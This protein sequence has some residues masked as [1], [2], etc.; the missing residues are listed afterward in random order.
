MLAWQLQIALLHRCRTLVITR[1]N[2]CT[3]REARTL[4]SEG[5]RLQGAILR[6]PLPLE[7]LSMAAWDERKT[8]AGKRAP[9]GMC[10][11]PGCRRP[12]LGAQVEK[13]PVPQ[14]PPLASLH[15]WEASG[16]AEKVPALATVCYCAARSTTRGCNA[17]A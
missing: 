9:T 16:K 2:A 14:F 11:D 5:P 4:S 13:L 17:T 10:P 6:N 8:V 15:E 7:V 3:H 12:F 1:A